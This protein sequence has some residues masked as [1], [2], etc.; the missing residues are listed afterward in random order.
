VVR[1]IEIRPEQ[2]TCPVRIRVLE[3]ATPG[4]RP[5]TYPPCRIGGELAWPTERR[6]VPVRRRGAA[7]VRGSTRSACHAAGPRPRCGPTAVWRCVMPQLR[8]A[9]P[10]VKAQKVR[11]CRGG[12]YGRLGPSP[13]HRV[14]PCRGGRYGRLGPSLIH[15]AAGQ[16]PVVQHWRGGRSDS[17]SSVLLGQ[18]KS[19]WHSGEPSGGPCRGVTTRPC[20]PH[21]F[22]TLVRDPEPGP[23]SP[24]PKRSARLSR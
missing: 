8:P 6:A 7:V 24:K 14:L 11:P 2:D 15:R 1:I 5:H 21:S 23:P 18:D 17:C 13:I 16:W 10:L 19:H 20:S 9:V 22:R 3:P 12:Q 4:P